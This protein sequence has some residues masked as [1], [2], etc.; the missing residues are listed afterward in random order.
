[1][2]YATHTAAMVSFRKKEGLTQTEVARKMKTTQSAVARLEK[3]MLGDTNI[4]LSALARYAEAIGLTIQWQ[5]KPKKQRY[6][7]FAN[8]DD[9]VSFAVHSSACEGLNTPKREIEKLKK[10]ANGELSAEKLIA[11]YIAKALSKKE[12]NCV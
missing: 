2:N 8:A 6:G 1:M 10:V 4:T 12:S 3:S 7:I 9:A 11:E 5:L